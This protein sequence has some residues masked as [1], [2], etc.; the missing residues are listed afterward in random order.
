MNE[1]KSSC[2]AC[3]AEWS[4]NSKPL[5]FY[6][7]PTLFFFLAC[8]HF[9][10]RARDLQRKGFFALKGFLALFPEWCIALRQASAETIANVPLCPKCCRIVMLL[11]IVT[12][13]LF[14]AAI[15]GSLTVVFWG[16]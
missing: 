11:T 16:S 4:G 8:V 5:S 13:L 14:G 10:Q 7:R 2:P 1:Q 9:K 6:A 12:Y 15:I 3:S